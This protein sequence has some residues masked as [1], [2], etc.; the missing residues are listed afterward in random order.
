MNLL[1]YYLKQNNT[2]MYQLHITS[3]IPEAT[4][5]SI[6]KRPLNKWTIGQIESICHLV[7][8]DKF[9][10]LNELE[11]LNNNEVLKEEHSLNKYNIENRRYIG[12]KAKLMPW[13]RDLLK[14][15]THGTS[16]LDLFSGTGIVI[17][18][19]L[20]DYKKFIIND[21]LYSNEVIY[22]A[23]YMNEDFDLKKLK[24]IEREFQAI[25]TNNM[26]D[27]YIADNYGGKFFSEYD[28][29]IIGEIRELIKISI[30]LN[31]KE[32]SILIASL[33]YSAD[34]VSNTVGHY[35]AYRKKIELKDRFKFELINPIDTTDKDINIHR[36]DANNL[37]RQ[38]KADI[39]FIDPP[40]NSRQYS[41]FYHVLEVLTKWE[42]PVLSGVAMKPET[43][44]SSDY[45][46]SIAPFVFDDLIAN[47]NTNFIV[48][49]YNNTYKPKSSSSK[50]K[51]SHEQILESLNKV[52]YTQVFEMPYKHF[53]SGKTE[54]SDHKEMV[55]ITE[56]NNYE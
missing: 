31:E 38:V 13:I 47:L 41:R 24:T 53:N 4:I 39:T 42:K 14:V 25:K 30:D 15:H 48:V 18:K 2:N 52:G 23:F 43:E 16:F 26:D 44:N 55:F 29:R 54:F 36:Q 6:N 33:L 56:V 20:D 3:G 7:R 22:K 5:R 49:T 51:I 40:Y 32:R 19:V 28:A 46:K 9:K 27:D 45:S 35:D 10:V 17:N 50:N 1:S 8:K 34:K 21:L 37:V 12:S 11:E